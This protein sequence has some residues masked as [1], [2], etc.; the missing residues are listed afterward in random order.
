MEIMD[1]Y[2]GKLLFLKTT[3]NILHGGSLMFQYVNIW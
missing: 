2:I 1:I 3:D